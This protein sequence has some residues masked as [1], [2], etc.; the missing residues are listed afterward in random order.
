VLG[1]TAVGGQDFVTNSGTLSWADGDISPKTFD[2]GLLNDQQ[3]GT[4]KTV[5]LALSN[6][7]GGATLGSQSNAVLTITNTT[8][9]PSAYAA[10]K[11]NHFGINANNTA[12][13]GDNSDPD[14]DGI[15]NILE[16]AFGSD[17]NVANTNKPLAGAAISNQFQIQFNRNLSATDLTYSAQA[18]FGLSD[19]WSNIMTFLPSSG[20]QTN[21][22]G[23][24][25]IESPPIGVPPDAH[26]QVIIT[27]PVDPA[28]TN[29][30]FH[31]KVQP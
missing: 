12:V 27:D 4:N 22:P 6:A 17:P 20:W 29:R 14:G 1:G 5:F 19:D 3:T 28:S 16:Y 24:S 18:R 23:S 8:P 31:L 21:S 7:I 25:V 10:W 9:P 30:F 2:V 11:S 15:P 26:V 13:A